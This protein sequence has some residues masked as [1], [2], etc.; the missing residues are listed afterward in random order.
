MFPFSMLRKY[1]PNPSHVI[2]YEPLQLREDLTYEELPVKLM[3]CKI[4]ELRTK[5]IPLVKVLWRNHEIE[6]ASWELEDDIYKKY[7]SL[8]IKSY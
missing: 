3:D 6:E 5:S 8:F 4:Q 7:P 2:K 1:V